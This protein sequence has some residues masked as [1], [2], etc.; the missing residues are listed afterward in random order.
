MAGTRSRKSSDEE[1][2]L[3]SQEP[4]VRIAPIYNETDGLDAERILK[5]GGLILDPWQS[6]VL[7]DWMALDRSGKWL[8][9]T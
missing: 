1:I 6:L 8:C 5:S 3:G 7:C 2:L 9:R 4:C